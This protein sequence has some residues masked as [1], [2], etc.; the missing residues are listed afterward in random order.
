[1]SKAS[2]TFVPFKTFIAMITRRYLVVVFLVFVF[3]VVVGQTSDEYGAPKAVPAL[4][5]KEQSILSFIREQEW[6]AADVHNYFLALFPLPVFQNMGINA[7]NHSEMSHLLMNRNNMTDPARPHIPGRYTDSTL[8]ARYHLI[9]GRGKSA[10]DEAL[11]SCLEMEEY[12]LH[13]FM[14]FQ[15]EAKNPD[16]VNLLDMV[17]R[18]ARNHIRVLFRHCD[19]RGLPY[20][21]VYLSQTYFEQLLSQPQERGRALQ[22]DR[23]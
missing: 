10:Q 20:K 7:L 11:L 17:A 18:S 9:V 12:N 14:L 16:L 22:N 5:A 6:M 21:P 8:T 15:L 13:Q 23:P 4:T 3:Q 2:H 1:M 19:E